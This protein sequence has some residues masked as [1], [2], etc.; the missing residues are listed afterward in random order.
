MKRPHLFVL[1]AVG[2]IVMGVAAAVFPGQQKPYPVV[3]TVKDGVKEIMNPDFPREGRFEGKLIP[4]MTWGEE[5]PPDAALL[6]K[7]IEMHVDAQGWVYVLDWGDMHIKVYGQDGK[8]LRTIGRRGQ[9][10]GEFTTPAFMALMSDG[11]ICL[12]DGGQ[13]RV[14]FLSNDGQYISGFPFEGYFRSLAVDGQD[15]LYL[16]KWGAAG[17]PKLSTEFREVP[18][19]TSI[20][21]TD[22]S[23]KD[24][25]H[26]AD[27]LGENM[28]MKAMGE[29]TMGMGG[30]FNIA[31]AVDRRGRLYGGFN[32]VF[33]LGAYGPD[34]KIEFSFGREF[35][36][37]KNPRFSGQVGQKKMMPAFGRT[38]VFDDDDNLWLE[39]SKT[40]DK[41]PSIYDIFSPEG[42]YLK[43]VKLDQ[44]IARF[45]NGRIYSY[46]RSEAED[47]CIKRYRLDLT[48]GK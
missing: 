21:R 47:V 33:H 39:L 3:T 26:L 24:M 38:I 5:G 37:L 40:D 35:T 12:L 17:E 4:E 10:P 43:Q 1:L 48:P 25:V 23:G 34:G 36:P 15:R 9:G 13:H 42:I 41:D 27:F 28:V 11:R 8:F 32:E 16:A 45:K 14:S 19:I 29:G 44:R 20:F 31:W 2:M 30:V 46:V 7:P 22:V 18:Y 6:N